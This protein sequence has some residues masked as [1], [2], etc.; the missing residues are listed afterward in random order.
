TTDCK[1]YKDYAFNVDA[2]P[3]SVAIELLATDR[4]EYPQGDAV[5]IDLWLNNSGEPQ[6]VLFEATIRSGA[7][8]VVVDG[9][10][11]RLLS[12]VDGLST[13]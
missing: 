9:L 8:G 7:S 2:T 12:S 10:P 5:L 6:D 3:A 11:L 1:F 4:A 13:Y